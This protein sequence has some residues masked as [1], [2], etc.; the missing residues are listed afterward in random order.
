MNYRVSC[1]VDRPC[2]KQGF[3]IEQSGKTEK[4]VVMKLYSDNLKE[5]VLDCIYHALKEVKPLVKHEDVVIVE[6]QNAHLV[7]WLSGLVEYKGYEKE[8]DLV[9]EVLESID[10]RYRFV[11]CKTPFIKKYLRGMELTETLK[12]SSIKDLMGEF[13]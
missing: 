12:T 2:Q 6:V 3:V 8:L 10:C 5:S 9:F 7:D 13:V 11:F 4:E 1:G